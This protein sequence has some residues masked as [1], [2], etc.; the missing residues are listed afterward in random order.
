M[1]LIEIG[2]LLLVL[3]I[4]IHGLLMYFLHILLILRCI[5]LEFGGE[6]NKQQKQKFKENKIIYQ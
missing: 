4:S 1:I 6:K 5:K 3:L 2:M